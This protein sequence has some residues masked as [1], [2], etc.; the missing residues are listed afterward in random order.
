MYILFIPSGLFMLCANEYMLILIKNLLSEKM[1]IL[2]LKT[3]SS[4]NSGL[5]LETGC[6][7]VGKFDESERKTIQHDT[8]VSAELV[9]CLVPLNTNTINQADKYFLMQ[10]SIF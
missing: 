4:V 1:Y 7:Q 9:V 2:A 5:F 3:N 8:Q 6:L 10:F